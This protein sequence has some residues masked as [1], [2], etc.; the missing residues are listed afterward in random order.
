VCRL[1]N[2]VQSKDRLRQQAD[3]NWKSLG[4]SR[5]DLAVRGQLTECGPSEPDRA[6]EQQLGER[7]VVELTFSGLLRQLL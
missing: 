2:G 4:W 5:V 7:E 3:D 6:C 1:L